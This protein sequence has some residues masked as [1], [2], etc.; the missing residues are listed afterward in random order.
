MNSEISNRDRC[1]GSLLGGAV[2]DALGAPIEFMSAS[3]ISNR[4]GPSGV[5]G[6]APISTGRVGWITDDTQMTLFTAEGLIRAEIK[7]K[8]D[9]GSP[10][11]LSATADS[12]LRWLATQR[13]PAA[14]PAPKNGWLY[15]TKAL[16]EICAPGRTCIHALQRLV[17]SA[18]MRAANDS[19]GCGGVMRVASVGLF[20]HRAFLGAGAEKAIFELGSDLAR[21]THGHP[22][23]YL[24]AGAFS[25][26]I[27]FMMAGDGL[28][29]SIEQMQSVLMNYKGHAE[30]S[31][32]IK[33]A[34]AL[35]ASTPGDSV[36]MASLGEGWIAEEALAIAIYCVLSYPKDFRKALL[37]SVNHS[38]DSDSTGSIVGNLL[39]ALLGAQA[40]PAEWIEKLE[41]SDVVRQVGA[42]LNDFF[43]WDLMADEVVSRYPC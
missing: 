4:F 1:T 36:A 27:A 14:H 3:E 18:S 33:Q 9:G 25:L 29:K 2:G 7:A 20:G 13:I 37:L 10:D 12:Y 24:S 31:C 23:G 15:K 34:I 43:E 40:I 38:G 26:L 22:T 8:R 19:K 17:P 39:G 32:A 41:L 42:D 21:I 30:T 11:Y 6:Y 28:E 35:A 5:S 16:H